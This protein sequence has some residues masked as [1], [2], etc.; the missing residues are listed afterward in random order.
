MKLSTRTR[1]GVRALVDLAMHNDGSPVQ[2][3]EI[4][5]REEI[6]EKYLEHLMS[7]LKTASFVRSIRGSKGGY[8]LA[9]DAR[10]INLREV[11]DVLEGSLA[12]VECVTDAKLCDRA[13]SCV[14][15][16]VWGEVQGV[17][18]DVLES[19]TLDELCRRKKDKDQSSTG[20]YY[21]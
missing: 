4:A 5:E 1:Y 18:N 3:R 15:R 11:V 10:E 14:T 6:S 2:L 21:I 7:L 9:K 13:G 8:L 16:D 20:M 17:I 12:P 19:I